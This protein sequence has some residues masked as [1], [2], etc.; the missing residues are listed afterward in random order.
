[1]GRKL[2]IVVDNQNDFVNPKGLLYVPGAERVVGP[3]EQYL[4]SLTSEDTY[5]V[6][7]TYDTHDKDTWESMPESEQFPF[8]CERGT[9]GWEHAVSPE[10]VRRDVAVYKLLKPVFS[11]WE[12]PSCTVDDE[13]KCKWSRDDFFTVIKQDGVTEVDVLGVCSDF[14][15][16]W[17]IDG[18]IE[19]GFNVNVIG[20]TVKGIEQEID[21]VVANNWPE[22]NI[23]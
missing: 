3:I 21:Q 14:C 22:V 20:N 2:V 15:V 18:L 9:W 16:K 6:L 4:K 5:G 12:D 8:H 19:R 10:V 7:F 17:A 1:M 23:I 11:M 13:V